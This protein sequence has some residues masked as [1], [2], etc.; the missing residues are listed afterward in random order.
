MA[1]KKYENREVV[2]TTI[3]IT[4]A[5]DGLSAALEID[6]AELHH[7][8]T[9]YIALKCNVADVQY[10]R[11]KKGSKQLVRKHILETVEAV[12]VNGQIVAEALEAQRIKVE[13]AQGIERLALEEKAN[14]D[15]E[16]G[17]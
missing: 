17:R 5:G 7:D 15:L 16:Q 3:K 8:E 14:A 6:P 4:R 11:L 12:I 1:L 10:P 13:Q 2:A 9:V